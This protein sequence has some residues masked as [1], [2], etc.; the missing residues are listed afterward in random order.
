MTNNHQQN[1]SQN[2][3][4][5]WANDSETD[6]N[7]DINNNIREQDRGSSFLLKSGD[8][9]FPSVLDTIWPVQTYLV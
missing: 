2:E 6:H 9:V 8:F 3:I 5:M 7:K 4:M 1:T